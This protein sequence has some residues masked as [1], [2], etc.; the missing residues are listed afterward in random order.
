MNSQNDVLVKPKKLFIKKK[1]NSLQLVNVN[2]ENVRF[3]E[4]EFRTT[5]FSRC[6]L[7]E[8]TF[9]KC[10]LERIDL[11]SASCSKIYIENS[12]MDF[13]LLAHA[14]FTDCQFNKVDFSKTRFN[15]TVLN[16]VKFIDCDLQKT[17]FICT[18]LNDAEFYQCHLP[19]ANILYS[20]VNNDNG[21]SEDKIFNCKLNENAS[22][23][24]FCYEVIK[25]AIAY[26]K[27][28]QLLTY[29][30]L[31]RLSLF[32][33]NYLL[34]KK[35]SLKIILKLFER[36]LH[37]IMLI[38]SNLN[39]QANDFQDL[40]INHRLL[41]ARLLELKNENWFSQLISAEIKSENVS[42]CSIV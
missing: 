13:A 24:Q 40:R 2:I 27:S 9:E 35:D 32:E 15:N 20:I 25:Y 19:F 33:I 37:D 12:N 5:N 17:E 10:N 11:R 6:N 22:T 36:L 31:L 26:G 30:N 8:I 29:S 3:I 23:N 38:K 1:F 14:L 16:Q 34:Y 41:Y 21:M 18:N 28:Y 4:C 42:R 39:L 7:K